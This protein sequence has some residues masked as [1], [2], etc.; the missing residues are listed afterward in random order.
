MLRY[1]SSQILGQTIYKH[2]SAQAN[3]YTCMNRNWCINIGKICAL[4]DVYAYLYKLELSCNR[5]HQ[6]CTYYND[7]CV[8]VF[9]YHSYCTHL[10]PTQTIRKVSRMAHSGSAN[11][12]PLVRQ[13]VSDIHEARR[14]SLTEQFPLSYLLLYLLQYNYPH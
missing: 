5:Q 8:C 10:Q 12:N 13:S 3:F 2:R 6:L 11:T 14:S 7:Q 4:M 1:L 9:I